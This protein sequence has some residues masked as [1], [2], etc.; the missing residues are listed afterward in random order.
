MD[1]DDLDPRQ[2]P[3]PAM[4][5]E[6]LSISDLEDYIVKLTNEIDRVRHVISA[7]Q[8]VRDGA[9]NLFRR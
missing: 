4:K 5:L 1:F 8:S 3:Q 6:T 9:A 2:A 7:K